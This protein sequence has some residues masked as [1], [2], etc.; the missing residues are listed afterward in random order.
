MNSDKVLS[1]EE[2]QTQI[3]EEIIKQI[4]DAIGD[5]LIRF[6]KPEE[7]IP[8]DVILEMYP[9]I[10]NIYAGY[11]YNKKSHKTRFSVVIGKNFEA[12][13]SV[14]PVY[15]QF[16]LRLEQQTIKYLISW[17]H[18]AALAV[19]SYFQENDNYALKKVRFDLLPDG[20][21]FIIPDLPL[22]NVYFY[23]PSKGMNTLIETSKYVEM[24]LELN[25]P[26]SKEDDEKALTA[27]YEAIKKAK[28]NN[29]D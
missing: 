3:Q 17:G 20:E 12:V 8:D 27:F 19:N 2:M 28:G 26:E 16:H 13:R 15:R 7:R 24:K 23:N 14:L 6:W 5:S 9:I 4:K 18:K 29:S 22:E 10:Y 11:E 21:N 1:H 25:S